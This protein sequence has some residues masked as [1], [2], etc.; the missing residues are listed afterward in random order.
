MNYTPPFLLDIKW[1][2][3]S[4]IYLQINM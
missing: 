2:S 1:F 4:M 3:L